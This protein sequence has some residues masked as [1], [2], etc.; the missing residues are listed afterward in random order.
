MMGENRSEKMKSVGIILLIILWLIA[1][2]IL[3]VTLIGIIITG[4]DEWMDIVKSLIN[5]L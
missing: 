2:I 3:T 4:D 5:K 1:T